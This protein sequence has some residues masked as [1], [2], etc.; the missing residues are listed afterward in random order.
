M[1]AYLVAV[2]LHILA[3][4]FWVGYILFWS[5]LVSPLARHHETEEVTYL[6]RQLNDSSWPPDSV[7][8][9]YR[10]KL[11]NLGWATLVLLLITGIFIL[12]FRGV[13]LQ[14]MILEGEI[15]S[16]VGLVLVVKSTLF[17]SISALHFLFSYRPSRLLI[18]L[19]LLI[20]VLIIGI[21]ILLVR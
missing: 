2:Y 16:R 7:S 20:T 19:E 5:I 18:Y 10:L 15:F 1:K 6:L 17:V 12:Y 4:L 11:Y 14:S 9:L 13:T 21:S 3:N 8:S